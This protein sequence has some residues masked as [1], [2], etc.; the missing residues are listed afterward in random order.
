MPYGNIAAQKVQRFAKVEDLKKHNCTIEEME[1]YE[2]HITRGNVIYAGVDYE[3]ILRQAE[4]E[5]DIILW[6][7]GNNDTPFYKPD[8]TITVLDPHRAGH[9]LRYYPGRTNVLLPMCLLIKLI[10]LTT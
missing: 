5:A 10:Q 1:E 6:D 8:L 3:A 2:P 9:E 7:G 4:K